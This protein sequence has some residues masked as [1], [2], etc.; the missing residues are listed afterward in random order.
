MSNPNQYGAQARVV[1]DGKP[2]GPQIELK[3]GPTD[4][5]DLVIA[6]AALAGVAAIV[7]ALALS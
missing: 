6:I 2:G 3:Q 5:R 1:A 7:I 4:R